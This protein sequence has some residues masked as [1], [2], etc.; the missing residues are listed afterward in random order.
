MTLNPAFHLNIA[1][2]KLMSHDNLDHVIEEIRQRYTGYEEI[3]NER[4]FTNDKLSTI[5]DVFSQISRLVFVLTV[6][7]IGFITLLIVKITVYGE[8]RELGIFKALGF[9]SGRLRLQLA[10]RFLVITLLGGAIGVAVESLFG[11]KLFSLLMQGF[12][13]SSILIEFSW[14]Y[15]VIGVVAIAAIAMLSAMIS[16]RNIK[17][18]SVYTLIK[19]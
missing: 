9:S 4:T 14:Q 2:V 11:S 6:V 13:L 12:G 18:V 3:A 17:K 19:E 7:I 5:Q 16:S 15:A 10:L 8:T 1:Y